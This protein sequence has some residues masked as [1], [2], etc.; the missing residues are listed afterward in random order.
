ME[1]NQL[2][3]IALKGLIARE[4][5]VLAPIQKDYRDFLAALEARLGLDAG[6]IGTKYRI[7]LE[8]FNVKPVS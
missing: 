6:S 3:Q 7:D 4:Q 1:L 5:A 8:T 2:E